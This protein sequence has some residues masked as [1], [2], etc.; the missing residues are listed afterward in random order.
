MKPAQAQL[1]EIAEIGVGITL[2]GADASRHDPK[3]THQLIRISDVSS[4]GT[5]QLSE[6]KQLKL[7]AETARRYTLRAGEVL[8]AARGMRMT[9][10]VFDGHYLAVAGGQF[11]VVRPQD[12]VI[13]PDYLR[14]FLN[15]PATQ[16]ILISRARGSYVRSLPAKALGT[17]EI[18]LP[19]LPRQRMIA[20][21][22]RLRV[23]EKEFMQRLADRRAFYLDQCLVKT[24]RS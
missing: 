24:L 10:T 21:V 22:D 7:D 11:L 1:R 19:P 4:D 18:P 17:L 12:G 23:H 5:L 20:E 9:A 8:V 2:R 13:L 3:G 6:P 16:E 14:W 15:L